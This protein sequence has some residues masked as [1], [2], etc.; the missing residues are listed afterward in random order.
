MTADVIITAHA[1]THGAFIDHARMTQSTKALWTTGVNWTRL[2]PEQ[3]E[4]LEMISNKVS[5]VLSGNPDYLDHWDD[6]AGYAT[7]VA[8]SLRTKASARE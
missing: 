4:A 5:R 7:L 6:I 2:S 3:K 8:H 1:A